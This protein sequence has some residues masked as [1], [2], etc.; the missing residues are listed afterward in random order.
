MDSKRQ[1]L[2][3]MVDELPNDVLQRAEQALKY[4][5]N[6]TARQFT[7]KQAK[8]HVRAMAMNN[9]K[10]HAKRTG[11]GFI[12]GLGSGGG[13]TM[14]TGD[15]HSSMSAWDEGPVTYHLRGFSGYTFEMYE[16][17]ELAK[18]GTKLVLTQ[19]IVGPN[20]TEQLLT[21]NMPVPDSAAGR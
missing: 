1:E 2:H 15:F 18:D 10:E 20:G 5:V 3:K 6:P 14:P 4:C 13:M 19:R 16:R 9:L 8:E 7:I 12:T 17:L 11:R 21:A